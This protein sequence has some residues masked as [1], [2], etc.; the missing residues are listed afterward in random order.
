MT[1]SASEDIEEEDFGH[2][3]IIQYKAFSNEPVSKALYPGGLDPSARP[4]NDALFRESLGWPK[5]HVATAKMVDDDTAQICAF[6]TMPMGIDTA[7]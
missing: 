6:A 2:L 5:P 1:F 4:Q 3:F 7:R